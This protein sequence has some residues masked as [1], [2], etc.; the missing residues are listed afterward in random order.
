[1][2]KCLNPKRFYFAVGRRKFFEFVLIT[3]FI[4]FFYGPLLNML[5]LAFQQKYEFPSVI[6][7]EFGFKWWRF[8]LDQKNLVKSI[9]TSFILAIV[10]TF[11]SMLICLPAAYGI[12]RFQFRGRRMF[13]FS[14]L[15]TN[16]FPKIG[17]YTSIGI[18]FIKYGLMGTWP[19][20]II[21]HILN[22]MLYMVWLPSSSF[23]SVPRQQ[24]EASR[25]IGAGPFRTFMKVTLPTAMPGIAVASIYTFLG[26][27]ERRKVRFL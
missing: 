8:V 6:P 24:E 13:L 26:S 16:A 11:A 19:G 22:T 25:D 27:L 2:F 18:L 17:I 21:I 20:V 5:M 23:R 1:M 14:F 3:V 4:L 7:Q 9:S 10:T 12:A 15:L